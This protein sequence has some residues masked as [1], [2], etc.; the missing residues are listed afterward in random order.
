MLF[1][2]HQYE[3]G[4]MNINNG[5]KRW[6]VTAFVRTCWTKTETI[7]VIVSL[8][9]L[10]YFRLHGY[11]YYIK[12]LS[13]FIYFLFLSDEGPNARSV[14]LHYP[15]WQYTNL[16]YISTMR[17]IYTVSHRTLL[18]IS[19]NAFP[20]HF[21]IGIIFLVTLSIPYFLSS[22]AFSSTVLI[23]SASKFAHNCRMCLPASSR[24]L[25]FPTPREAVRPTIWNSTGKI[26]L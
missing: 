22:S 8:T 3:R 9:W 24:F 1:K 10:A 25:A 7:F 12:S 23:H 17:S 26:Y 15:F 4:V 14:K 5:V 18:M 13:F 20:R 16:F 6:N 21:P 11:L 19:S 2:V